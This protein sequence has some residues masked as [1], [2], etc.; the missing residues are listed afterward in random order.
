MKAVHFGAGNIGRGFV[1]LLLH[2]AGY[3]VVFADVNAELIDALAAS[4]QY[5][6]DEVGD[7]PR[8]HLLL[9]MAAVGLDGLFGRPQDIGHFFVQ[10]SAGYQTQDFP[11]PWGQRGKALAQLGL[12]VLAVPRTRVLRQCYGNGCLQRGSLDR[13]LKEI[14][15]SRL[16]GLDRQGDRPI[17]RKEDNR[18]GMRDGS[19][20]LLHHEAVFPRKAHLQEEA[21]RTVWARGPQKLAG[22]CEGFDLHAACAEKPRQCLPH[23]AVIV[24]HQDC[25]CCFL[26]AFSPC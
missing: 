4:D 25:W 11:L 26:H 23:G 3:E 6:A 24:N 12:V 20:G 18:R 15:G 8:L 22:G 7:R 13:L 17:A 14:D 10:Q 21:G 19:Q 16:H 1:G 2:D 5:T 9:D